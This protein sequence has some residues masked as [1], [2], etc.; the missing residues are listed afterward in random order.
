MT[1]SETSQPTPSEPVQPLKPIQRRILGVLIEKARTTPDAYPLTLNALV[2]GCN[3]KSN[4]HPLMNLSAE[5]VD[6][7]LIG[8]REAG[9][10]AEVHGGGRVPKFRHFGYDYMGVKGAEAG[11]MTELLLRG[12]QTLGELRS[13]ASRFEPIADMATLQ[14][15]LRNLIARGLVVELTP[16]G[17]GQ[18]VT[19]NLYQPQELSTI[20]SSVQR[21][22]GV[23]SNPAPSSPPSPA[24]SDSSSAPNPTQPLPA[25]PSEPAS[26]AVMEEVEFLREELSEL[27]TVVERLVDRL[28]RLEN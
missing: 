9:L 19:H 6:D 12:E 18:L 11:I 25:A 24:P 20:Q 1:D 4:R 7:E 27:R 21:N 23:S 10:V 26:P 17:R 5:Q 15:L 28:D 2:T 16:P 3:Q 22:G 14:T 8:M 13:R